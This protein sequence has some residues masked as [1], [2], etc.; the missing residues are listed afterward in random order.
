MKKKLN[1]RRTVLL[2]NLIDI[3]TKTGKPV[4]SK[5]L[6]RK[7]VLKVSP[8]TIRNELACL[9]KEGYL[10][11]IFTSSGRIPTDNGYRY[12]V[13]NLLNK[14]ELNLEERMVIFHSLEGSDEMIQ[15]VKN[16]TEIISKML[17]CVG[18][19]SLAGEI[20]SRIKHVDLIP[21]ALGEI[22][23]VLIY[24][25]GQVSKKKIKV[26]IIDSD[27]SSLEKFINENLS[28]L[29]IA[30]FKGRTGNL[31]SLLSNNRTFKEVCDA[32]LAMLK[33]NEKSGFYYK[34]TNYLADYPEF[35]KTEP[36][37]KLLT[38]LD[39]SD[40]LFQSLFNDLNN[41]RFVIKIGEENHE[42][43]MK[44]FTLIASAINV[45]KHVVGAVGMLGPKRIN[46]NKAVASVCSVADNV[47]NLLSNN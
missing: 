10:A 11:H 23:I 1:N 19:A 36:F 45:K 21:L 30:E 42:K 15:I 6:C 5:V 35:S 7:A 9:E 47:S 16:S 32:I 44:D 25:S 34:G 13:N 8:A 26:E 14:G 41:Y 46:Y 29:N 3:Y 20:E 24:D 33:N 22:L 38:L 27:I 37:K 18:I 43:L 39:N 28:G 4:S 2:K 12:Y 17:S 40:Y 31:V